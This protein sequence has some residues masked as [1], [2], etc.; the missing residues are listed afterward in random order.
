M[1][2]IIALI[3]ALTFVGTAS[4]MAA[5]PETLTLTAKNGD[6]IF[7]HKKHQEDLKIACKEC[8]GEKPGKIEGF[9]KDKAHALCKD[10]HAKK[11]PDAAKCGFCHK[12]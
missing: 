6:V 2:K 5:G 12:K 10:C 8:H 3:A 7:H 9:G 4:V 11:N 1:K